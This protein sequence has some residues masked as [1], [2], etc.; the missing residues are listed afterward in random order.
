MSPPVSAAPQTRWRWLRSL[1]LRLLLVFLL[2]AVV[3]SLVFVTGARSAFTIGVL[4]VGRPLLMDYVDRLT[5]EIVG[6]EGGPPSVQRAQEM[7][8]RLPLVVRIRGPQVNWQSHPEQALAWPPGPPEGPPPW[9]TRRERAAAEAAETSAQEGAGPSERGLRRVDRQERHG[10]FRPPQWERLSMRTTADGHVIAFDILRPAFERRVQGLGVALLALGVSIWLAW[11]FVRQQL[12]P[13][14]ALGA[15]ARRFGAGDFSQPIDARAA[16]STL[17]LGTLATTINTMGQDIRAMLESKRALLLAISHELRSPLTR[18]RLH[19][20]LLPELPQLQPQRESLLR[21]LEEMA[22]LV[23]DLLES[24]RL[25]QGHAVLQ[26][27]RIDLVAL[28]RAVVDDARARHD[29]PITLHA[30]AALQMEADPTRLRLLLRNVLDNALRYGRQ[31][32]QE[33]AEVALHMAAQDGQVMLT[34][35]DWGPGVPAAQLPQ[36][37]Q[38]FYRPDTARSRHAGGVGLGL[39]LCRLIAQSHGGRLEIE[40]AHPGLQVRVVLPENFKN[41]NQKENKKA[42][43]A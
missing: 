1:Q 12:R 21:D 17:E 27:E 29:A 14:K 36:L 7:T 43:S 10:D 32:G 20:E 30:P 3:T 13:L 31:P 33:K 39:Y 37:T 22:Q 8:Q 26:R 35:R 18:A 41:I 16:G 4:D 19:T 23:N 34:V 15:G 24:E 6:P 11:W 25:A 40:L 42:F 38:A 5:L 2:L 9:R 28:A